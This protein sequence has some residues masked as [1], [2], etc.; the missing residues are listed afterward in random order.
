VKLA[1]RVRQIININ[2]HVFT[3]KSRAAKFNGIVC[4]KHKNTALASN[5]ISVEI[6]V[7]AIN[8]III[9]KFYSF[10]DH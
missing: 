7:A 3:A 8:G 4:N 2:S 5:L 6:Q 1:K 10:I 9:L